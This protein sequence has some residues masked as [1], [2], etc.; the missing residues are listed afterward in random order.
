MNIVFDKGTLKVV[1]LLDSDPIK[2]T[3]E[4]VLQKMFP[5]D[6]RRFGIWHVNKIINYIPV[7]LKVK[8]DVDGLPESLYFK[9]KEIY[10]CTEEEK[11]QRCKKSTKDLA[12]SKNGIVLGK[13]LSEFLI[14]SPYTK[15][16]TA[17]DLMN[18]LVPYQV[19]IPVTWRGFFKVATGYASICRNV[20]L[21]LH[22][23]GIFA[24]PEHFPSHSEIDP[25]YLN[26][27]SK[28]ESLRFS[29]HNRQHI[30]IL[31]HTP[32]P[33]SFVGRKIIYTM[34]ETE[35]LHPNFVNMC[36]QYN[37]VWV[38]C[39]HNH[40]LFINNGVRVPVYVIPLG[41]DE[42]FYFENND[43]KV[44]VQGGLSPLLG[45]GLKK[46]KFVSIAQWHGRKCPY[47]LIKSFV[48]AFGSKDDVCLIVVC[49]N[50]DGAHI[51]NEV[52]NYAKS[53]RGSDY[54]S[55]FLYGQIPTDR[56]LPFVYK[57]CDAF[58]STSRGEGFSLPPVEAAA[59]GLP[60]ISSYNTSMLDYLNEDNAYIVRNTK[61]EVAPPDL[62]AMCGWYGG[63]L[64]NKL[65]DEEVDKFSIHMKSVVNNYG[66]ALNRAKKLQK[67]VKSNYTWDMT[68]SMVARRIREG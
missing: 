64:L 42:K 45:S 46:F 47:I 15:K 44:N 38:P 22:N 68:A 32:L 61:R 19:P 1:S 20:V 11:K 60:V 36:N 25:M 18:G 49:H 51:F 59:C 56:Q 65:G 8:L 43:E 24:K 39:R 40:S 17:D 58:V 23:Y 13:E 29:R 52:K 30:K 66:E 41:V 7:Y 48:K 9:G 26:Y 62:I 53:I 35:T 3:E 6:F 5:K 4:S 34:M 28:Y 16:Q 14:T 2:S 21:R 31:A 63:Q 57:F 12:I 33:D 37:E 27:L 55:I 54:P 67:L 10:R 50:A